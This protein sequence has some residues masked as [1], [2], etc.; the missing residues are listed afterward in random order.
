LKLLCFT[1]NVSEDYLLVKSLLSVLMW[2]WQVVRPAV[3]I[4]IAIENF[5]VSNFEGEQSS[6]GVARITFNL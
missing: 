1:L 2:D 4:G 3:M 6:A 5:L